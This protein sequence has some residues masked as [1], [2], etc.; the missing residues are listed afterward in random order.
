MMFR[1]SVLAAVLSLCAAMAQDEV[2]HPSAGAP[3]ICP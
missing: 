3:P 2:A 1:K